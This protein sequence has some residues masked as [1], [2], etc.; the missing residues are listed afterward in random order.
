MSTETLQKAAALM[1]E[2]AEN[3]AGAMVGPLTWGATFDVKDSMTCLH[4]QSWH[5][6]VAIEV[7]LWLD[8]AARRWDH[9]RDD[10]EDRVLRSGGK[11]T[12]EAREYVRT[13]SAE[14]ANG[15]HAHALAVA[16][17]YLRVAS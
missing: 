12:A 7:A 16:T 14:Y 3:S 1:R 8:Q 6:A 11:L 4:Y 15:Q 2:R 13:T 9:D 10:Y 5:P 17:A